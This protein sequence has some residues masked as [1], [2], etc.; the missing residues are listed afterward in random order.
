MDVDFLLEQFA[1]TRTIDVDSYDEMNCHDVQDVALC[2]GRRLTLCEIK[3]LRYFW[4]R[5]QRIMDQPCGGYID[6]EEEK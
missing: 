2:L 5:F 1:K 3:R 6:Y 4:E